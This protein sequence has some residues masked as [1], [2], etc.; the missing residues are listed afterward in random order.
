MEPRGQEIL[1]NMTPQVSDLLR[2]YAAERLKEGQQQQPGASRRGSGTS[3]SSGTA[4]TS[5][6]YSAR[7]A[8]G[9]GRGAVRG[10]QAAATAAAGGSA[11]SSSSGSGTRSAGLLPEVL[12]VF[13]DGLADSQ[14]QEAQEK[15]VQAVKRVRGKPGSGPLREI[16]M[17]VAAGDMQCARMNTK[18]RST[19]DCADYCMHVHGLTDVRALALRVYCNQL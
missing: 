2:L 9:G 3:S 19:G 6:S 10:S 7:A 18:L 4:A 8:T 11:S 12:L 1:E 5:S 13:R 15:E 16:R 17:K 14:F